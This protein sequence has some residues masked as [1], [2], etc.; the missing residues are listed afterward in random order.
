M[1]SKRVEQI[2]ENIHHEL[3]TVF[4]REIEFPADCLATISRIN[5]SDDLRWAQVWISVL[6]INKRAKVLH[7]L[8]KRQGL[9]QKLL[10]KRL[11]MKPIPKLQFFTDFTEEKAQVIEEAIDKALQSE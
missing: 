8:K 9:I 4:T 3:G 2:N 7:L 5:V 6:P 10:N 11:K 1:P